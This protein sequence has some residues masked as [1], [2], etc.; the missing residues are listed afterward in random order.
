[1]C[2]WHVLLDEDSKYILEGESPLYARLRFRSTS[3]SQ[4]C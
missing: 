2:A 3:K 1:V 4:G